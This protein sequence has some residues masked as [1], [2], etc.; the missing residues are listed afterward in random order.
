MSRNVRIAC[1]AHVSDHIGGIEGHID[2]HDPFDDEFP[3]RVS[4]RSREAAAPRSEPKKRKKKPEQEIA[5]KLLAYLRK[6]YF[7]TVIRVNSGMW[8]IG[9]YYIAGAKKGTAD[10]IGHILVQCNNTIVPVFFALETK[11]QGNVGTA[12]QISYI[13]NIVK[14]NGIA[15]IASE[16]EHIEAAIA[17]FECTTNMQVV[18]KQ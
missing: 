12:E 7:C 17:Q 18:K 4:F 1:N 2:M 13:A 14:H 15:C 9:S 11:A 16:P 10:Y 6:H 3:K 8:Q 5:K